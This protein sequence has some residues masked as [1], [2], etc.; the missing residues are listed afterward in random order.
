MLLTNDELQLVRQAIEIQAGLDTELILRC[1][2]LIHIDAFDEAVRQAFVLLEERLRKMLNKDRATGGQLIQYAFS[3]E[4]PFTKI[5]ADNVTE[6]DGLHDLLVGA[7]KLYR[8]PTAHT[9]VGYERAEARAVI[10]LVDLLLKRLDRLAVIPQPGVLPENIE[11]VLPLIDK[12]N[13]GKVVHRIRIFI[14]KCLK[15]GLDPRAVAKQWLP[16][17]KHALMQYGHWERP[18]P[19]ALTVFYIYTSEKDQG[20]WFPVNQYY[21]LVQGLDIEHIT[22][23]L[24]DLGFKQS[25]KMQDYMASFSKQNSQAFFDSLFDLVK[26]IAKDLEST[27]K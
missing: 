17:R 1:G 21:K 10:N 19:H 8:N 4:G 7:F 26:Q 16:F 2:P 24:K 14:G 27:L 22:T 9:I 25:G 13:G 23:Q 5:M 20:F 3:P 18:K 15:E 11:R 6:R 12:T